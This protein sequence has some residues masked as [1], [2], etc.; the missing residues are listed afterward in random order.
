MPPLD[1]PGRIVLDAITGEDLDSAIIHPYGHTHDQRP[2]RQFEP[3]AQVGIQVHR[4]GR[5]IE[6]GDGQAERVGI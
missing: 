6:L 5:L 4:F 2:L 3:L 1:G